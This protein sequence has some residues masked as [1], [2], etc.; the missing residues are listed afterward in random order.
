MLDS[1]ELKR[2]EMDHGLSIDGVRTCLTHEK[3]Q[4]PLG[5]LKFFMRC[6]AISAI[7]HSNSGKKVSIRFDSRYRIDFFRFDSA[8]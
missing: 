2:Q 7:E 4:E 5:L 6:A 1:M 3:G 8:I